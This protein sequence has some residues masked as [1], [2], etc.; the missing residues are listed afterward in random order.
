MTSVAGPLA[1]A[2][3]SGGDVAGVVERLRRHARRMGYVLEE[4][5]DR[6]LLGR[7]SG[8]E[9]VVVGKAS[10]EIVRAR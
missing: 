8:E 3:A 6:Y 7:W 9:W 1:R 10:G 5:S 4:R 2:I